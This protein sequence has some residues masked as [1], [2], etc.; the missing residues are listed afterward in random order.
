M[1]KLVSIRSTLRE[2]CPYSELSWS[3]LYRIQTEYGEILAAEFLKQDPVSYFC[4]ICFC[5]FL[6][7]EKNVN[8]EN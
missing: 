6:W 8:W 4:F 1:K 5:E 2:K 3:A 7:I